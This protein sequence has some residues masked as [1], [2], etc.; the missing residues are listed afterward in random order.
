MI[1]RL[2]ICLLIWA[3]GSWAQ[4]VVAA[5][6]IRARSI[7]SEYDVVEISETLN[8]LPVFIT[9]I[10]GMEARVNFYAGRPISLNDIAPPA[11]L[12]R[13][14]MVTMIFNTGLLNIAVEGRVLARAGVGEVVRVMNLNSRKIVF[15][16]VLLNGT[17]EV[18]P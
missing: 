7:I 16:K 5:N 3:N 12:E 8:G 9:D 1:I 17:V 14:Q 11:I 2:S 15:G 13:N 6:A 10:V 18:N 4:S